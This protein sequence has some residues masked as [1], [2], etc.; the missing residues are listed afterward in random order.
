MKIITLVALVL[1]V[2]LFSG[3]EKEK[4]SDASADVVSSDVSSQDSVSAPQSSTPVDAAAQVSEVSA[5]DAS[6]D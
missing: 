2:S 4:S 3:C 6:A 5:P 1:S